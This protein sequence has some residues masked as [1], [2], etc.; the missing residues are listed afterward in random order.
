[1]LKDNELLLFEKIAKKILLKSLHS[2][3]TFMEPHTVPIATDD[4]LFIL[5]AALVRMTIHITYVV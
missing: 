2:Y 3:L 4:D 5:S 1:M